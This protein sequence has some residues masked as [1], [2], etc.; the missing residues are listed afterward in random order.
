MLDVSCAFTGHR[1]ARFGFGYD[2]KDERCIRLKAVL[3]EQIASLVSVGVK[4]F[5]SGMALGI[6]QWAAEIVLDMKKEHPG[7][8]LA[9]IL[10][11]ETQADKWPEE[12]RER[13][14]DLLPLCDDVKTL[15]ARYTPT[16]M[17]ERDRFLVDCAGILLAVFDGNDKGGTAY[18]VGYAKEKLRDIITIHP[19]TLDVES[20]VDYDA[21]RRRAQK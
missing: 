16:C 3:A 17:K 14:F 11:C 12:S 19:D 6:D 13:Y 21:L 9:A 5:Y 7:L 1:P 15:N 10:P 8:Y 20:T 4:M 18:T 2:E